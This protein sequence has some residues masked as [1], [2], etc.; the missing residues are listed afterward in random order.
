MKRIYF[1]SLFVSLLLS[2]CGAPSTEERIHSVLL[3]RPEKASS[4]QAR[5]FSGIVRE[6][7][8]INLGFK[9][10]G[11][12]QRIA[13]EEGDYVR[14]GQLIAALDAADY[15]LGV[16]ALQVQYDQLSNEVKRLERLY[17][18][19]SLSAND[20]EKAVAGLKQLGVQLQANRNK[21][22]YTRLYAPVS[23]YVRSVNF[24]ESE[25]VDAGTPVISLLDVK[26]ME[27][28]IDVPAGVYQASGKIDRVSCRAF[29]RDGNPVEMP[30]KLLS[31]TP[32]ADATQLYRMRLGF[33]A[34]PDASLT[35]GMNVETEIH[36]AQA[37]SLA[38]YTLPLRAIF[39]EEGESYVWAVGPDSI[40]YK[41][42]VQVEGG[43]DAEGRALVSGLKGDEAL[44]RAGV[45]A[46]REGEKVRP[47]P[48]HT[49]TNVGGLL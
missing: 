6:A 8:E 5:R 17:E 21:L 15:Q 2:G 29:S 4:E 26:G 47:I 16:D 23:G 35:A 28:E 19:R 11:Q 14:Q 20:Y 36:F 9:T 41:V 44:V 42:G 10:P 12:I 39:Q 3:T 22:D 45:H 48:E 40:I 32:K 43:L 38:R 33:A 34:T 27:V 37:D 25:M 24:E 49:E 46:L 13:V 7:S 30:M 1:I 31:L 18:G